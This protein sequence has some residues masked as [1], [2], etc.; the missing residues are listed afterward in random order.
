MLTSDVR[1][2]LER[3]QSANSALLD[4]AAAGSLEACRLE[5]AQEAKASAAT[6]LRKA[7]RRHSAFILDREVP[8]DL[9]NPPAQAQAGASE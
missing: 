6:E 8:E 2:A 9:F 1:L 4:E 3:F 5:R 7:L